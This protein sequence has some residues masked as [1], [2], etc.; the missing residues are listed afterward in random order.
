M[1][2][3]LQ[4]GSAEDAT[5]GLDDHGRD[6]AR[7]AQLE[8]YLPVAELLV[9]RHFIDA[10]HCSWALECDHEAGGQWLALSFVTDLDE[11]EFM[12]S[13]RALSRSWRRHAPWPQVDL[14]RFAFTTDEDD[15]D[16][17]AR[18]ASATP[19][20][21]RVIRSTGFSHFTPTSFPSHR[22]T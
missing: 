12:E 8:T 17:A 16:A 14:I 6:F 10:H 19:M 18:S 11:D 1:I 4:I 13:Y 20:V 22:K 2:E 9:S 15:R 3:G 5:Q 21:Q 7:A